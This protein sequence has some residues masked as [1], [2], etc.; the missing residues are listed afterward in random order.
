MYYIDL[1]MDVNLTSCDEYERLRSLAPDLN[2][3]ELKLV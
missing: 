3:P 1:A 2:A